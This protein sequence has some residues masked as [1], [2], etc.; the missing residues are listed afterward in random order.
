[1][2]TGELLQRSGSTYGDL[3]DLALYTEMRLNYA[4]RL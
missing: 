2:C 4:S 3:P 1:M